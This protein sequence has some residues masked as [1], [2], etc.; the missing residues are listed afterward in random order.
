M[1]EWVLVQLVPHTLAAERTWYTGTLHN[2]SGVLAASLTQEVLSRP[3]RP[4]E[5]E[6]ARS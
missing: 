1:D 2:L 3:A 4:T 5:V 6:G